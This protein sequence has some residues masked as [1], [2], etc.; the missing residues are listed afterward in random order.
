MMVTSATP[1]R[2]FAEASPPGPPPT[3]TTR[4]LVISNTCGCVQP[5]GGCACC[6]FHSPTLLLML[7]IGRLQKAVICVCIEG[8][9]NVCTG[10]STVRAHVP[11]V[12]A[13]LVRFP[14]T[15]NACRHCRLPFSCSN[16]LWAGAMDVVHAIS[17]LH[18]CEQC[19]PRA[20]DRSTDQV[21]RPSS[22]PMPPGVRTEM[23]DL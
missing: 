19:G 12:S 9:Q 21:S 23:S 4:G 16:A 15:Q 17:H 1:L 5:A 18:V 10:H 8:G 2:A 7:R 11:T 13:A 22:K 6:T 14:G 3:I 20:D